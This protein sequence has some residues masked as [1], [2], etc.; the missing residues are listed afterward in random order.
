MLCH[1]FIKILTDFLSTVTVGTKFALKSSLKITCYTA[2][3]VLVLKLTLTFHIVV[4]QHVLH[5]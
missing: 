1:N 2:L 3:W 4:Y 5:F